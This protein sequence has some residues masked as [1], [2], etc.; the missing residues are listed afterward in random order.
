MDVDGA[1]ISPIRPMGT[2]VAM[3]R[4]TSLPPMGGNAPWNPD[5]PPGTTV[6]IRGGIALQYH[7]DTD[8]NQA[9]ATHPGGVLPIQGIQET[10]LNGRNARSADR[11]VSIIHATQDLSNDR[12]VATPG[13][14]EL[15]HEVNVLR[16]Q[17]S[18]AASQAREEVTQ[19]V[20]TVEE[21]ADRFLVNQSNQEREAFQR[22][23]QEYEAKAREICMHEVAESENK[24]AQTFNTA[25]QQTQGEL[26]D[27]QAHSLSLQSSMNEVQRE[28][29][30]ALEQQAQAFD[31][32]TDALVISH[33][34][35]AQNAIEDTKNK[36]VEEAKQEIAKKEAI[37]DDLHREHHT[38]QEENDQMRQH[39]ENASQEFHSQI[40]AISAEKMNLEQS[41]REQQYNLNKLQERVNNAESR[42]R[43]LQAQKHKFETTGSSQLTDLQQENNNLKDKLQEIGQQLEQMREISKE[44]LNREQKMIK[45]EIT[46]HQ[47]NKE[48]EISRGKMQEKLNN[49]QLERNS[50]TP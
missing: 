46:L 9:Q 26:G 21:Y 36:I 2:L 41:I 25:L 37:I 5:C 45:N 38:A 44:H 43:Q 4:S 29:H 31:K 8:A 33:R 28:A 48:M 22:A 47:E 1:G 13:K 50:Q 23:A 10:L 18:S 14:Q 19:R 40:G 12:N 6:S 32:T 49:L 42:E 3:A 7:I 34:E 15:K 35:Q 24:I 17:L 39:C 11:N 30:G 27:A 16:Q 20:Q